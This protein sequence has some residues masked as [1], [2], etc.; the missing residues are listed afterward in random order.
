MKYNSWIIPDASPPPLSA[1]KGLEFSPLLSALLSARGCSTAEE[2]HNYL[3]CGPET[4]SDAMLMADMPA[5][6]A[7]L[8]RAIENK[9]HIGVYGDYDVDGITSTVLL[10][11]WLRDKG[12]E[13]ELY[14]PDR[15]EEGYGLNAAAIEHLHAQGVTLLITVDCG[16][17]ALAEAQTARELGMDMIVTDH[18]ECQAE[19]PDCVAV[20]DPKR[21]DCAGC[22]DLAGVGVAFKLICAV[23][24]DP[25]E[26]LKKWGDLVAVGTIAD[27]MPL[28]GEN[29][30]IVRHGLKLLAESPR[31]GLAALLE[32]SGTQRSSLQATVVS[33]TLAPRI[34]AAGRLGR[35]KLAADLLLCRDPAQCTA[36][37]RELC[38][39]NRERQQLEQG[40][41]REAVEMLGDELPDGPIVL[42]SDTW[43]QGVVGIAASRLSDAY[44][45]PAI[46]I[47]LDG[48][49]GR[50]SCRSFGNFNLFN[51][52]SACSEH[53]ESYGGHALAAGLNI[54]RENIPAFRE[55]MRAYYAKH[56]GTGENPLNVDLCISSA[57][58]LTLGSVRDLEQLEPFGCGNP[59]P[60][61]CLTHA[62][63]DSIT[64]IGGGR[65]L[66]LRINKFSASY[67]CI[68]FSQTEEELGIQAGSVV[69]I[70]FYPQINE[71]RG[72]R[73]VMF[74]VEDIRLSD[75]LSLCRTVFEGGN[76]L[77]RDKDC[78][79]PQR[80]DFV[81]VWKQLQQ[82]G[83]EIS[84]DLGTI[85]RRMSAVRHPAMTSVCLKVFA[86]TRLAD[87]SL[88]GNHLSVRIHK[89]SCKTDLEGAP[90]MQRLRML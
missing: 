10:T 27:V 75:C 17:T 4:L 31:P 58:M 44:S 56:P 33:Y 83:G 59:R 73:S 80:S 7:R 84:G 29:R 12:L 71:Y 20:V 52:L 23:E 45:R 30:F 48:D 36:L 32:E 34:N 54:K 87:V 22:K 78:L 74:Y 3:H 53:L 51:A 40:I 8:R 50:G 19:L 64:P 69:D 15:I 55:A 46:M 42:A 90:L 79:L 25:L 86:E 85:L 28:T 67:S 88:E 82:A 62:Y 63:L 9:E 38:A 24:G 13:T 81:C 1:K 72:C 11:D 60:V 14:I 26:A 37:A 77:P 70:A 41:W 65:H 18:H 66:R 35:A 2:A 57:E 43:H 89:D 47:C 5:A 39:M 61:C 68:M 76:F 6:A 16:V 49:R 21:P